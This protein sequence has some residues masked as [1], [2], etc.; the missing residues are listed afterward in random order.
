MTTG[1][2][3]ARVGADRFALLTAGNEF[4]ESM[5]ALHEAGETLG[6][7]DLIRVKMPTQG[8]ERWSVPGPDGE[9]SERELVG[10][11][12][13]VQKCGVLWGSLT[14]TEG[15]PP[16]LRTWDMETAEQVGEIPPDMAETLEPW[17]TGPKT[18]N[19]S[20]L[21]GFPYAQWGT[22]KNGHGK[23]L[24]E[25]RMIFILRYGDPAP[26]YVTVQPGSLKGVVAWF[27]KIP[28]VQRCAYWKTMVRLTLRKATAGTGEPYS[29]IVAETC[30]RI[31]DE[32]ATR[33]R[34]MWG[35]QLAELAKR[36]DADNDE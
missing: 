28:L 27:K 33:L 5:Q 7:G 17:R 35:E 23:R 25:Q 13:H 19:V 9:T 15:K 14:T 29:Q 11:L 3:L 8:A 22:G 1:T 34:S 18:F 2:E 20:E 30:G 31:D 4:A 24:K 32:T 12:L 16:V 26:I 21:D 10:A 36:L 6:P